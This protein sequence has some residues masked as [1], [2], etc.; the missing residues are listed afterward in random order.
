MMLCY[1]L[2]AIVSAYAIWLRRQFKKANPDVKPER[3]FWLG[4][5]VR[6]ALVLSF[7]KEILGSIRAR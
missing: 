3:M 4:I 1:I 7:V 5:K 2:L 6:V